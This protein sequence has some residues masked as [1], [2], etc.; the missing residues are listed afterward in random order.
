MSHPAMPHSQ[1][2]TKD[3]EKSRGKDSQDKSNKGN[4]GVAPS[5]SQGRVHARRK[6]REE[7]RS[8]AP[9]ELRCRKSTAGVVRVSIHYICLH[10]HAGDLQC[11]H[12]DEDPGVDGGPVH[13]LFGS[14]SVG[15]EAEGRD[16]C[17]W[18]GQREAKLGLVLA[19][20][21]AGD[22]AAVEDVHEWSTD[23]GAD[24]LAEGAGD[25]VQTADLD[26][27]AVVNAVKLGKAGEDD[28]QDA[29]VES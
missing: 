6:E 20:R 18:D 29:V 8:E 28:V 4:G 23:L 14:P 5:V 25:V 13:E 12:E 7:E 10:R 11:E 24:D 27:L 9:R 15:E 16:G 19:I 21:G 26:G 3:P 17:G 22:H 2:R 1:S